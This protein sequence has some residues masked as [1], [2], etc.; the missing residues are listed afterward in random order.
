MHRIDLPYDGASV[1][2]VTADTTGDY[3]LSS[4]H[5]DTPLVSNSTYGTLFSQR[6]AYYIP[7]LVELSAHRRPIPTPPLP[8]PIGPQTLFGTF[9]GYMGTSQGISGEK[10]DELRKYEN[11]LRRE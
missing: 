9:M 10:V 7:P 5:P 1:P 2:L 8:V 11:Y 6:R 3:L 4:T